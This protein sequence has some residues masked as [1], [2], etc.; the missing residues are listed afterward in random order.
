[1]NPRF[2]PGDGVEIR[3]SEPPGHVRTPYYVRGKR[4]VV[5][6]VCGPFADPEELAYGRSGLPAR[7]LY[8]VRFPQAELW[9]DYR[10]LPG[11]CVE[12]EL[13]EHWLVPA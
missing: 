6:R 4:G 10:G 9:P 1:M 12:V 3:R 13:Y 2:A 7:P 8:R 5:E 11:D